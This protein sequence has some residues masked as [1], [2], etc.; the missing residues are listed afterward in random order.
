MTEV[1][2]LELANVVLNA[3]IALA[4]VATLVWAIRTTREELRS[5]VEDRQ[6][7]DQDRAQ[8]REQDERRQA[9]HVVAWVAQVVNYDELEDPGR[10][11]LVAIGATRTVYL[12]NASSAPVYDVKVRFR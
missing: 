6:Q 3:I 8:E 11:H 12:H 4:T 2:T 9:S 1:S 10:H 5:S 7:R